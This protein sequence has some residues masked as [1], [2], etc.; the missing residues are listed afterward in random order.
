MGE[1][2]S[3]VFTVPGRVKGRCL[4]DKGEV[5]VSTPLGSI[6][7]GLRELFLGEEGS[8]VF[9]CPGRWER[10]GSEGALTGPGCVGVQATSL[11]WHPGSSGGSWSLGFRE[12]RRC[13][14]GVLGLS[15][16]RERRRCPEGG[17]LGLSDSREWRRCS[18]GG[19]Q[20]AATVSRVLWGFL[21]SRI[22]GS[23]DGVQEA[24]SC[25]GSWSFRIPASGDGVQEAGSREQRRG[26]GGGFRERRRCLG[27]KICVQV[28]TAVFDVLKSSR[29]GSRAHWRDLVVKSQCQL[30]EKFM[31]FLETVTLAI[32]HW[33]ISVHSLFEY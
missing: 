25:R 17:V 9:T 13:P 21:V 6:S 10:K 32:L 11:R 2:G 14:V 15:D 16:S 30:E 27:S 12:Q 3:E 31:I 4:V 8:R 33:K 5:W 29:D 20:G 18:G 7:K 1:G 23:G 26:T 24:G 19:F 22:P 28:V